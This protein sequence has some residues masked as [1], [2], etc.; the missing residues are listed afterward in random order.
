MT[1]GGAPAAARGRGGAWQGG[2]PGGGGRL[3]EHAKHALRRAKH[4]VPHAGQRQSE[5]CERAAKAAAEP[6]L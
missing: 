6:G 2:A 3:A 4:S 5:A 1:A